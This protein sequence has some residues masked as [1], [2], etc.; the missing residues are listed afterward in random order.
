[1]DICD[2]F[3]VKNY[4]TIYLFPYDATKDDDAVAYNG[5]QDAWSMEKFTHQW[6]GKKQEDEL[7]GKKKSGSADE[8]S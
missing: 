5:E 2:R 4:P 6:M 3:F 8:D 1:M 7:A